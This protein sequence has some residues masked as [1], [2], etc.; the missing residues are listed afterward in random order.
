[1]KKI[2]IPI[3]LLF[4]LLSMTKLYGQLHWESLV[5]EADEFHYLVL[6]PDPEPAANWMQLSFN[7]AAWATGNGGFGFADDDDQTIISATT[8]LYL[9]KVINIPTDLPIEQ[10][11]LDIDYDDAFVAYINGVE[12]ARSQNLEEGTPAAS[13][14]VTYDHEARMYNGGLPERF[15]LDPEAL[16]NGDNI[17]A[18]HI[19]NMSINSSDLS[20][21]IFLQAE[22]E[23]AVIL[24]HE[25]PAW[26]SAPVSYGTTN[27]PIIKINTEGQVIPNE[28]KI[29]AFMK[30]IDNVSGTN[31]F[32]DTSFTYDGYIG[33]EIRGN[34]AQMFPKKSYT[35]ETRLSTGENNNVP[36]L[37]M[38]VEND[39]VLHG[40]YSDKSMMRNALAYSIGN[41]M[42]KGW[43]PRTRY[44]E[45][46]INGEYRGV[47]LLAEKIKIDKNRVD[48]ADLR[49]EDTFGD[50][51]TGG[52]II[53]IDRDQVGSWNSPFMGRTGSV[54][55]P[56]SY[57]DPKYDELTPEQRNY[58][59]E[60]ITDFEY[61][62]HGENYKDPEMGYRPY[63]DIVSFIDYF[64]ITE[65]SK[66]LDGYRVSV[67]FH[68]D[69]DSNGGKL[70]M[71]PFWDYNICFGN[72][73]FFA[74]GDPVGWA[75]DGIGAGDSYEI[76]FWWDRF[77]TDPYFEAMLKN[78]WEQLRQN[79]IS[80]AR[81]NTIID[82]CAVLLADAQVRNFETY[83]IL[84]SYVWP[85]IYV[86][87]NYQNEVNYLKEWI[88]N[89][90]SWLDTQFAT[91]PENL[92]TISTAA[93][94][95]ITHISALVGGYVSDAGG[96][97]ISERGLYWDTVPDP[98]KT[99]TM[100]ILGN[101]E[102]N[103]TTTLTGLIPEKEYYVQAYAINEFGLAVGNV[104]NFSTE[105]GNMAPSVVTMNAVNITDH[106]SI[107]VGF[108]F[109][110]GG[111]F[112]TQRGIYWG[113]Q[114]MPELTGIKVSVSQ[115]NGVFQVELKDL[116]PETDYYYKA[117]AINAAGKSYGEEYTFTT[118]EVG[119][120]SGIALQEAQVLA[121]PNPFTENLTIGL[122]LNDAADVRIVITNLLGEIVSVKER[123]C[124]V[125]ISE[126]FFTDD[127]LSTGG[128]LYFYTV[129][130]D[131]IRV[132]TGKVVRR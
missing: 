91:I 36:L 17:L 67:Y 102:G 6:D 61:A 89:R 63:T 113:T 21:R 126:F 16:T 44:V 53:S 90:I 3:F 46:E 127:D 99:G 38:P 15:M 40:P 118:L 7:D 83:N 128:N 29:T 104:V 84:S 39:W 31:A 81:I 22:L 98:S 96:S 52:Y 82:S 65:L 85:N 130:V 75:S 5:I 111:T 9:R 74:A 14:S 32:D 66:D 69:K 122:N 78:R 112:V 37:G 27:L 28:P 59:R 80:K 68:K 72:A 8:S 105:P 94:A 117:Y 103:F 2:K 10:L 100:I 19:L 77:R 43:H 125:G 20:S 116:S 45:L 108:V 13:G 25:T 79:V 49:P 107:A 56:F 62:L 86:G 47:Y 97:L 48:I 129:L 123:A 24:F 114:T 51:L 55:V 41:A 95:N 12:V 1:M 124:S 115:G 106:S 93:A 4:I 88:D 101:G 23:S 50:E 131:N 87:G 64:I 58:I 71:T 121:Y 120:E 18:V 73:N 60:Y 57:V 35:I 92:P 54:D 34:T 119:T 76:P 110:D 33:I 30:V 42:G 26:F 70:T 11:M 109:D 132:K